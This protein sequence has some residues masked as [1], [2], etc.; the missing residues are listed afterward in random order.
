LD[1]NVAAVETGLDSNMLEKIIFRSLSLKQGPTEYEGKI[2][3][4]S[5]IEGCTVG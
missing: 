3:V 2:I 5:K 4:L 1:I